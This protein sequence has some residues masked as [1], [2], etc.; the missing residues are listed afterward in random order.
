M[1]K[2]LMSILILT[3]CLSHCV[4]GTTDAVNIGAAIYG[5]IEKNE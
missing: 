2:S 3:L 1:I 4:L 5:G